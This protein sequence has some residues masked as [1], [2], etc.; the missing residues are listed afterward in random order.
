M[1]QSNTMTAI[2]GPLGWMT[3]HSVATSYPEAPTPTEKELMISWLDAFRDTITCP[4]C[5]DHFTDMLSAY[6]RQ[7]PYMLDSR[8]TF[9]VATFRMH[10]AVNRRLQK[11]IYSSVEECMSTLKNT[12]KATNPQDY[13]ISYINHVLR[14]WKTQQDTAGIVALRKVYQ[15]K[16]I[17]IEYV[18]QRDTKFNVTIQDDI[19]VLPSDVM[20]TRK[21]NTETRVPRFGTIPTSGL[22]LGAGGFRLR[23]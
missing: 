7:Y 13:R 14:Y 11:P 8:Q 4:S 10:N 22:V 1:S 21:T 18:S 9:T 15:L 19:V 12:T 17:E 16:K 2:W 23:R 20:T 3:L 5:R 6:R